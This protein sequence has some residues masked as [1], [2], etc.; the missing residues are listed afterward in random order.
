[1]RK[2]TIVLVEGDEALRRNVQKMLQHHGWSVIVS[3]DT[4]TVLQTVHNTSPDLVIVGSSEDSPWQGMELAQ[5]LHRRDRTLPVILLPPYSSEE[6]VI[7]A[8]RAG[9]HDYFKPPFS[10]ADL[11]AS[12]QSCLADGFAQ[13]PQSIPATAAVSLMNSPLMIGDSPSMRQ[14][15]AY[16]EKI[17]CTDS[18]VLIT[19]ET[20][21]G[22]ELAAALLHRNSPRHQ[23]PF[24]CLNCAAIPDSLLESELFGYERGA[25]TGAHTTSAGILQRAEGGTVFFDEIGDMSLYAQAK[26]L[27]AIDRK[28]IQRLGG[29]RSIPLN[30][31]LIAA[32]NGNVEHL[33]SLGTFRK[34]LYFR[35]NV[36]RI[37]LPPLRER[38]EDI[39]L[40]VAYY[41]QEANH[42]FGREVERLTDEA[43]TC[44]LHYE[45]PGNVRELKNLIEATFVSLPARHLSVV[46]LPELFY[47]QL[48]DASLSPQD[49]QNQ[50]LSAL[51]TTNWNKSKAAQQLH[52]SRMTLYRKMAK[53]H[54]VRG[55]RGAV[56]QT[57]L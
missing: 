27:R 16:I 19:G 4:T 11:A 46:D 35:L 21:T 6:L 44:L 2:P 43:M 25:F 29:K 40:L 51:C 7:A 49:E 28:E 23:K 50:I 41:I 47:Q 42:R 15:K 56:A 10:L 31:R 55:G 45:W 52:W 5:H 36:V 30:I 22:K 37:L 32:T 38:K 57:R 20:G 34:D 33:V 1:M 26:I 17:A 18:S 14:I 54:I 39:P 9:V 8:L 24:L 48:R 13:K 12:A 53:Y 3:L